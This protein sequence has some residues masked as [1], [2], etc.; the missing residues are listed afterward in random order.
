MFRNQIDS[1]SSSGAAWPRRRP[2]NDSSWPSGLQLGAAALSAGSDN[3]RAGALPSA[4]TIQS[5]LWRRFS[6]STIAVR[7]N[8][9]H[10]PSGETA[11]DCTVT[12]RK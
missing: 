6:A 12:M 10:L 4:A 3:R 7:M 11:G 1:P 8:A 2:V 9:T 5:S